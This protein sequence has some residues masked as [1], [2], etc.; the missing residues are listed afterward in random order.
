VNLGSPV[1]A[2]M[3]F[4][5]ISFATFGSQG[6][7]VPMQPRSNAPHFEGNEYSGALFISGAGP[8]PAASGPFLPNIQLDGVL[9][10]LDEGCIT[11]P[12]VPRSLR[13]HERWRAENWEDGQ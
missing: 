2:L 7:N 13:A 1:A 6:W 12:A 5:A 11:S 9:C 4:L 8:R 10:Q 3:A